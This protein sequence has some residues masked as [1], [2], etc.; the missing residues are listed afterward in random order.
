MFAVGIRT[1]PTS[2]N[3]RRGW[4]IYDDSTPHADLVAF[5][6]AAQGGDAVLKHE[7]PGARLLC[8][9]EVT[10]KEW[11]RAKFNQDIRQL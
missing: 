6:D 10:P 3:S 9:L 11:R 4:L 5:V 1:T 8:M 2:G 7:M